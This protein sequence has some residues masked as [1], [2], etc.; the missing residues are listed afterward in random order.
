MIFPKTLLNIK[1]KRSKN[2]NYIV[3]FYFNGN[4]LNITK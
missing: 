2:K 4:F 1:K 3:L